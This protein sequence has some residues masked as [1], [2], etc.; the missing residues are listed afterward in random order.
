MIFYGTKY[1]W[2]LKGV[3]VQGIQ[4]QRGWVCACFALV[5]HLIWLYSTL[6]HCPFIPWNLP[7]LSEPSMNYVGNDGDPWRSSAAHSCCVTSSIL[8]NAGQISI[9]CRELTSFVFEKGDTAI[10]TGKKK[11]A[12]LT[13]KST[14]FKKCVICLNQ[15]AVYYRL[16]ALDNDVMIWGPKRSLS[17]NSWCLAKVWKLLP[18]W[19]HMG[20]SGI[21]KIK[22]S[23]IKYEEGTHVYLTFPICCLSFHFLLERS[24][25]SSHNGAKHPIDLVGV[26]ASNSLGQCLCVCVYM[27]MV[28]LVIKGRLDFASLLDYHLPKAISVYREG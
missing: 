21:L 2:H 20:R 9:E 25:L 4:R 1:S 15:D 28:G 26:C 22:M 23:Q 12:F 13:C 10:S 11:R 8:H 16:S 19:E 3:N 27:C 7:F 17:K 18:P 24:G 5:F 14:I 6:K